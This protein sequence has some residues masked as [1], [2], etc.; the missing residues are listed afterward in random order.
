[1]RL[2][3][4]CRLG[5]WSHLQACLGWRTHFLGGSLPRLLAHHLGFSSGC[6]RIL[7]TWRLASPER[8]HE[9]SAVSFMT[10]PGSHT[11]SL[12]SFSRH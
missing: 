4:S 7:T 3:S 6:L 2:Q 10:S 11:P 12:P 8:E 1:M 9:G 5:L